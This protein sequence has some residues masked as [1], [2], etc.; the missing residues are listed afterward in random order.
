MPPIEVIAFDADDT[1]WHTE[2][3]YSAAETRYLELMTRYL[4]GDGVQ[5][6]LHE[7]EIANLR[8]FG[9]GIK[10][11]VLSLIE[12]A[13]ELTRGQVTGSDIQVMLEL[14]KDMLA[15]DVRLLM[16]QAR[17]CATWQTVMT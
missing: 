10:A 3:I 2:H 15:A 16:G 11:Y 4:P 12:T 17:S 8:H 9:Y 13:I 6:R 7:T 5:Q 1:L 14:G